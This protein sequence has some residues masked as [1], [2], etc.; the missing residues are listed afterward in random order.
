MAAEIWVNIG[1]C[2]GL[3]PDGT[4]PRVSSNS[5]IPIYSYIL[6]PL[7]YFPIGS[8][9]IKKNITGWSE[10][11]QRINQTETYGYCACKKQLM[12]KM[13]S[14]TSG[15]KKRNLSH[16]TKHAKKSKENWEIQNACGVMLACLEWPIFCAISCL[17]I[18]E[19]PRVSHSFSFRQKR[20]PWNFYCFEAKLLSPSFPKG[21]EGLWSWFQSSVSQHHTVWT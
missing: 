18:L 2:N 3:L 17:L 7:L 21:K 14:Q 20:I 5:Y 9:K 19:C 8:G 15:P 6:D 1:S 16:H 11:R 12:D 13:I 4:K 10:G